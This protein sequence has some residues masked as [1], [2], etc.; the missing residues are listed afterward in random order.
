MFTLAIIKRKKME[1]HIKKESLI[2]KEFEILDLPDF[3]IITGENG[4]GKTQLLNYLHP[5]N[6]HMMDPMM[7]P[8][9]MDHELNPNKSNAF[10]IVDGKKITN[11][12]T[13][14]INQ[15]QYNLGQHSS[16][17]SF[18]NQY[19]GLPHK[20]LSYLNLKKMGK[21]I[22]PQSLRNQFKIDIGRNT[23]DFNP[24]FSTKDINLF[25]I[26]YNSK[27]NK[28]EGASFEECIINI[29]NT[30]TKLFSANLSFLYFQYH[31]RLKLDLELKET[32]WDTFNKIVETANFRYRLN[33]P[34]YDKNKISCKIELKDI[35]NGNIIDVNKLSSG[36][37]TIMSLLLALYNSKNDTQ[38]PDV[39]ILDEPDSSLHP[40]MTQQMLDVLQ[41]VFV[42]EKGVKVIMTTHSPSTVALTPEESIYRMNR[43][44]GKLVKENKSNAIKSLTKGLHSLNIYFENRKHIFVESNIDSF[45]FEKIFNVLS[46]NGYIK[47]DL[48]LE[49][50]PTGTK[51]KKN[52]EGGGSSSVKN[53]V[54]SL[55]SNESV[56]G[57]IDFDN[58]NYGNE[59][60]LIFGNRYCLEN[61][62]FDPLYIS[63]FLLLENIP[64][65]L[66]LGFN[67]NE[68][69]R[70]IEKINQNRFQTIIDSIVSEVS[71][72][73]ESK[74]LVNEEN[75]KTY[76]LLNGMKFMIPSWWFTIPGHT[77]EKNI[78]ETFP[79]F[80]SYRVKGESYL[81]RSFIDKVI[82][83]FPEFIQK[84]VFIIFE[85]LQEK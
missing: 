36:E 78:L 45:Y 80:N 25:N 32:P 8:M 76:E 27:L 28:L 47:N 72:K 81:K 4:S 35:D 39:L 2:I 16:E 71:K 13:V 11:I 44:A 6:N 57:I 24:S 10:I 62:V 17:Q 65:R 46:N 5:I 69:Y 60:I 7:D 19:S 84:E 82:S 30:E 56:L 85:I 20:Y 23:K 21:P 9:M 3:L 75:K 48:I 34:I 70:N 55:I 33:K 15:H 79:I 37:R 42:K 40:S 18:Y 49:F 14:G 52:I 66:I 64:V 63:L 51:G 29:P 38:F 58:K 74:Y 12:S 68:T 53:I 54:N 26:I 41:N 43:T 67:E 31:Q 77:L 59:N 61:Y 50:I 83:V 73:I 22:N 1:I